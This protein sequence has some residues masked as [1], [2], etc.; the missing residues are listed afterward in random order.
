[1]IDRSP[2]HQAK[3][4]QIDAV[5]RDGLTTDELR[6]LAYAAGTHEPAGTVDEAQQAFRER[7]RRK[8]SSA[9]T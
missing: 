9:K 5:H 6:E 1:M 3:D 8:V 7:M 4:G 2:R